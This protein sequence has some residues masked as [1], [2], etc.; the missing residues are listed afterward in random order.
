MINVFHLTFNDFAENTFILWDETREAVIIDPGCSNYDER[1]RL[2]QFIDNEHLTPV[3]LLGTHAHID[4]VLGNAFVKE[5]YKI[6]YYLHPKEVAVLQYT[7]SRAEFYGFKGYVGIEPNVLI[8][9]GDTIKFGNSELAVLFVPG[10]T[11]GHVAYY[12]LEENICVN[13]DVLFRGSIGRTDFP[14]C[15][16]QDLIDSI[17]QKMFALPN[18]MRVYTGHGASTT[19]GHEKEWN[20]FVGKN[21]R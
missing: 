1:Q 19:I 16:H 18:N 17:E 11:P 14:M 2:K 4:H 8:E 5:T 13:G 9:E 15:N 12:N 10:H 7:I 3:A 20:P 21:A 6:P